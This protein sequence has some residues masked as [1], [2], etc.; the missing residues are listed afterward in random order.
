MGLAY[1][2]TFGSRSGWFNGQENDS[3]AAKSAVRGSEARFPCAHIKHSMYGL[4]HWTIY[5]TLETTPII[6]NLSLRQFH[7]TSL[8]VGQCAK[9]LFSP[10]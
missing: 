5:T 6:P 10:A 4:L 9:I 3:P 1:L 2:P 7:V 8:G